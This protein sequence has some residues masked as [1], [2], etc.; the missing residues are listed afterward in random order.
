MIQR[1]PQLGQNPLRSP[2]AP[3][4]DATE[5]NQMFGMAAIAVHSQETVFETAVYDVFLELA[6]DILRQYSALC[7]QTG[8]EIEIVFFIVLTGW[9][10]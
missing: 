8:Y 6:L 9:F 2:K 3:T 5:C 10:A 1:A 4:V 7:R